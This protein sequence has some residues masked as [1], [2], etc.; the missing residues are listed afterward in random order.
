[1]SDL[2]KEPPETLVVRRSAV[3]LVV[4]P[5]FGVEDQELA[6]E[7]SNSSMIFNQHAEPSGTYNDRACGRHEVTFAF[8]LWLSLRLAQ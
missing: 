8:A 3:I 6:S 1:M 2:P 4:A 7:R 5:E